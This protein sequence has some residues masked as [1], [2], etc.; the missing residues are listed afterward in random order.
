MIRLNV[1]TEPTWHDLGHGV[2][3][4]VDPI[5]TLAMKQAGASPAMLGTTKDAPKELNYAIFVIEVA[6]IVIRD[7]RGVAGAD[8]APAPVDA[9]HIAALLALPQIYEAFAAL[10]AKAFLLVTEK[11][12]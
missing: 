11:N 5:G 7:W 8:D 1:V 3:V 12:A 10:V 9:D 4:L 6:K 2:E